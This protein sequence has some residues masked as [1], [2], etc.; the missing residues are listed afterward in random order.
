MSAERESEIAGDDERERAKRGRYALKRALLALAVVAIAV[1][2]VY[3]FALRDSSTTTAAAESTRAVA[4]IGEGKR[5]VIVV[6]ADGRLLGSRS[7]KSKKQQLPVLSAKEAPKGKRVKGRVREEVLILAAAPTSLSHYIA[8]A[9]YNKTG[10]D[11]ETTSGIEIRF[12]DSR[13]AEKKWRALAAVLADP[14]V[15]ALSYVDV[16][17]P[18]RPAV[19]GEEH[20]LPPAS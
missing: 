15:T 20:E 3:W 13:Q 18:T 6:G 19:N 12:G 1:V 10:V 16:H 5:G 8:S 4:Q 17:A 11:L 14:S 2:A 7:G 9:D